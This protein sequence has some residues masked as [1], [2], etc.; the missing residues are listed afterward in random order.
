MEPPLQQNVLIIKDSNSELASCITQVL[1]SEL[2]PVLS[3]LSTCTTINCSR[4]HQS[5]GF[6]DKNHSIEMEPEVI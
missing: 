5:L 1:D 2:S 6:L 4:N 3:Q